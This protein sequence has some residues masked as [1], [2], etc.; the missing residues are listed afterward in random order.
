MCEVTKQWQKNV[1]GALL[2]LQIM[3]KDF[4][5]CEYSLVLLNNK[6]KEFYSAECG[7]YQRL[8]CMFESNLGVTLLRPTEITNL[9]WPG[10]FTQLMNCEKTECEFVGK[11][12]T[13]YVVQFPIFFLSTAVVVI[14]TRF[15]VQNFDRNMWLQYFYRPFYDKNGI[16]FKICDELFLMH[17]YQVI[18]GSEY[19]IKIETASDCNYSMLRRTIYECI[20]HQMLSVSHYMF[21]IKNMA[22]YGDTLVISMDVLKSDRQDRHDHFKML[23]CRVQKLLHKYVNVVPCVATQVT[24]HN[25]YDWK[26][27]MNYLNL[28]DSKRQRDPGI[29]VFCFFCRRSLM[30]FV[31]K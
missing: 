7:F 8:M 25:D 14:E 28:C 13:K 16:S 24:V 27:N 20:L 17:W 29:F 10:N 12:S 4:E 19:M 21:S 3:Q 22:N 2:V 1:V 18:N 15:N 9:Q 23:M 30:Y 31:L 26:T 6:S 5:N 11:Q